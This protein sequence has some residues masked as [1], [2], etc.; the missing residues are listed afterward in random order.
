MPNDKDRIEAMPTK[1]FFVDMLVRD[2]SLERAVLDLLD[3]SI[4]GAKGLRPTDDDDYSGLRVTIKLDSDYFVIE[5][6]CGGF[7]IEKARS[8]AFRFGRPAGAD[9]TAFSIGQF[10]VGMKR[11]LFKFGRY[12][13][14]KST[15][16]AQHWAMHV[17]VDDWLAKDDADW[18]FAFDEILRNHG[19]GEDQRGTRIEV[20]QLRPE[21]AARF[22]ST[23][24]KRQ[25]ADMIRSHQRRFHA[26]GLVVQFDGR[27]L[28]ATELS[29]RSGGSFQPAIEQFVF[30]PDSEA[31]VTVRLVV[32][33]ADPSPPSAGW[34]IVCNRRVIV[35]A[36]RS[37]YTGW[38]TLA[39]SRDRIPKYHNDYARFRGVVSFDC[40]D[41]SKM[42][43]NTTKTGLD[44]TAVVWQT[45]KEKMRDHARCVVD[46]L[47]QLAN[48]ISEYGSDASPL[49]SA[50]SSET[51]VRDVEEFRHRSMQFTWNENPPEVGPK[52]VRIQYS[53]EEE[54]IAALKEVFG[55]RSARA[56]GE[57][58]FDLVYDTHVESDL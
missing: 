19:L 3:N 49:L 20:R 6:N 43:W 27:P 29:V 36:D 28:T 4:D 32:G 56:V 18:A 35:A 39:E 31:P 25:L 5:D 38:G 37:E 47:N 22:G 48:E 11:A 2:I 13:E 40:E 33:V 57:S 16:P 14:V 7:D 55:V 24:F 23:Y 46:F 53:K 9:S 17:D 10:G 51:S 30:E 44:D 50:L 41:S 58:A 54:K 1:A 21:V 45:A 15:T 12:F 42:P 26:L 34:Y 52:M 8:Y